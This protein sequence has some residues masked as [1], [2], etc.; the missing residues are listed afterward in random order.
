VLLVLSAN[1]EDDVHCA[2]EQIAMRGELLIC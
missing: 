2:P 1:G